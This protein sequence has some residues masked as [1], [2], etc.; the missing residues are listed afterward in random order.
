MTCHT[1]WTPIRLKDHPSGRRGFPY[2]LYVEKLRT[3]STCIRPDV[4]AAR[5]DDSQCSIKASGFLSKT[6]IWEDCYNC[7]DDMDSRPDA[8]IHK[9]SIAIQIQTFGRQSSSSERVCI[10]YGNCVH[11]INR[12]D[13]HPPG[14]EA[15][16]LYMEITCSERVTVRTT[17]QH[18]PDAALKQERFS[19]KFLK[20]QSHSCP[21]GRP[22]T[23]IWT[24]PNFIKANAHLNYQPINRGP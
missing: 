5:P 6:Q 23:T 24:A 4:S 2:F 16:S 7:P 3:A 13:D 18:R 9:A 12:P 21:S 14:P 22:M 19:A 8:L 17:R 1:V 10:K 11:H 20:F 15:R